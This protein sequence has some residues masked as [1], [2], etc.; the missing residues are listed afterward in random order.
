MDV[1]HAAVRVGDNVIDT[2]GAQFN[3]HMRGVRI[4]PLKKWR[5]E[6]MDPH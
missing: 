3:R 4:L 1:G 5:Q 6:W 2:S